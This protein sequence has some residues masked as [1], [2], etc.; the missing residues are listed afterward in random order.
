MRYL[1]LSL[2]LLAGLTSAACFHFSTVL[3]VKADGSGTIDQR[4]LFTRAAV[5]QL[6]Q[7]A[8]LSGG[9]GQTLEPFS[10]QQARDLAGTLGSG[11][12]YVSSTPIDTPEGLGR[13]VTYAFS[14][15]NTL[16]LDQA[17]P[18]PG[19]LPMQA[20]PGERVSFALTRQA[21]GN[22]LLTITMPK[23]PAIGAETGAQP[24][25]T[26]S[27]EQIAML[28]PM[29]AGARMLIEIAPAG[30]LVRTSSPF[31]ADGRVT[32][33]DVNVD[34]LFEDATLLERL[35]TAATPAEAKAVLQ[36]VPGLK[37][38]LDPE[39]TIEFR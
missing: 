6:Q 37:L 20:G 22:A 31:V 7:L 15:I 5:A 11:V 23:I 34:A 17:P 28:K 24:S 39:L 30:Q 14:D 10:E 35:R 8:A 33:L 19:G 3:N 12:T 27:P 25:G 32:V 36:S 13:D 18:A 2:V 16:R 9:R 1:R 4:M 26:P 38:N 29:L 21:D